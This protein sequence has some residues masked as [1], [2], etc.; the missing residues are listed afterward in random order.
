MEWS[1]FRLQLSCSSDRC[2]D[3]YLSTIRREPSLI[4]WCTFI[5]GSPEGDGQAYWVM[6]HC[7]S[8]LGLF[9]L[10]RSGLCQSTACNRLWLVAVATVFEN[11]TC[12][13]GDCLGSLLLVSC[14][15]VHLLEKLVGVD[16][17]GFTNQNTWRG[18]IFTHFRDI[19]KRCN[20]PSVYLGGTPR[21]SESII[22]PQNET[23][24]GLNIGHMRQNI[25]QIEI[26]R[27]R[28]IGCAGKDIFWAVIP[29]HTDGTLLSEQ[30][31]QR[32]ICN[33][34]LLRS[35]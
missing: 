7:P 16:L 3:I 17:W 1:P 6:R 28:R 10:A 31:E 21:P 14:H 32:Y 18:L 29:A 20:L 24:S 8:G 11:L 34:L 12:L 26:R 2:A 5:A 4:R 23:H 22:A 27:T 9:L 33:A 19:I 25:G 15:A 35:R 13:G 30:E